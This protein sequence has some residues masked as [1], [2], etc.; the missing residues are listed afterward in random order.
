MTVSVVSQRAANEGL[1]QW[2]YNDR[3]KAGYSPDVVQLCCVQNSQWQRIRLSMKGVP[4]HEKLTILKTWWDMQME[5][6][7]LLR[8]NSEGY[9]GGHIRLAELIEHATEVQVGNYLGAL[10]RGGQLDSENRVRKYI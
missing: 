6:A 4:T 10:R 7:Q 3:V 9:K 8:K 2:P 5:R 1:Q